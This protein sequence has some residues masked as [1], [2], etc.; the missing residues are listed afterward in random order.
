MKFY[1]TAIRGRIARVVFA[2]LL[3]VINTKIL[4]QTGNII[5]PGGHAKMVS[6]ILI[7]KQGKYLYSQEGN[8]AI[9]WDVKTHSQLYT[10]KND[11]KKM[12]LSNDGTKLLLGDSCYSTITGK[13]LFKVKETNPI[14][15]TDD[16]KIYTV[17]SGLFVTDVATQQQT[18]LVEFLYTNPEIVAM[19]DNDHVLVADN[20]G[21][22]VID[23]AQK[24]I[25]FEYKLPYGTTIFYL[26]T[27]HCI[28]D[29]T[30][31]SPVT[32][33]D[34][35]TGKVLK[36]IPKQTAKISLFSSGD[37]KYF[38]W[39][40]NDYLN[41]Y[42]VYNGATW[43][44]VRNFKTKEK[45]NGACFYEDASTAY[46]S[47]RSDINL[48]NTK[49]SGV[50]YTF[51]RQV[52]DL[53]KDIFNSFEYNYPSGILN[54]ITDDSVYKSID[55][56]R[57]KPFRHQSLPEA[58]T[59]AFS[60]TGDTVALFDDQK[61]GFIKNV[62]TGK[63]LIP[64][65]RLTDGA[66]TTE[67]DNFFFDK[68][69]SYAYYTVHNIPKQMHVLKRVN[70]KTGQSET[71]VT[72]HGTRG[73]TLHPDKD[74]LAALDEGYQYSHAKVWDVTTG[75]L[76]FDKDLGEDKYNYI[77]VS[78]DKKKVLL[79]TNGKP[80][81][82]DLA[83][84]TLIAQSK[85]SVGGSVFGSPPDLSIIVSGFNNG[86]IT[87]VNA[88]GDAL[89]DIKAHD[90]AVRRILFS[91]DGRLL[92]T[93]SEDQTIKVWLPQSGKLLG[94]LYLFNDG[95]D[96][97]F[98]DPYGR[99]DGSEGGMKRMYYYRNRIKVN[100]DVV[101]EKFYTPNLYQRLVNG[102]QFPPIDMIIN[103]PPHVRISYAQVTRNLDV[104]DDKT[105]TYSNTSGI[106]EITVN[107][108]AE[109][110]KVD[111]IRLFHNGKIV[112]LA[113]RGLF[114]T[115][116]TTG[117]DTKKYTLNLLPGVNNIRAVAL[118]G[119]RTES[120]PDEITIAYNSSGQANV[121]APVNK[122]GSLVDAVDHNATMHLVVVGI[123]AYK[124]PKMS[125]NYALADA[126]S[127][128]EEAERNA[129]TIITSVKTY[130]VTDDKAD[131]NGI[132]TA[133][134]EVQKN[135]KPQDVFVFYYAGH[136]VI[137]ERNKEFYLV[138]NDVADLK[139]VDEALEQHGIPSKMLQQYAINIAAQ[140]QVFILDACQS[141]G[142]FASLLAN[143]ANQ[144]KS[145]AV[146]ARST[147]TH[148]IAASGSQQFANE[149][150]QLGHGAF[151]YVL[152]KAMKG[153]AASDKMVT[154]NGLKHFLQVQVPELMKKYNGTAQ[155]PASYGLGNDFPV[156]VI[157]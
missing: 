19:L 115:D 72:F 108:S 67:R 69:G 17:G 16:S 51:K 3:I 118:N 15:S 10:F 116:N 41:T 111:E 103:P 120:E 2:F 78:G 43:A 102:E 23:I 66:A 142:A 147:G 122:G 68:S 136:G 95:N 105:P 54:L 18:R 79:I 93:V 152:L 76:L 94:T 33:R 27:L 153:E 62:V 48:L 20:G 125:L 107:A 53:G 90:A 124:N 139:N 87:A 106:A 104:V 25:G 42:T 112:N 52:A 110:D 137:S 40:G 143:D 141:A 135:A 55:M 82:Y 30:S 74:L 117:T 144:Q 157:K 119:Q 63:L 77:I 96:Y 101:Y 156:G 39:N 133:L 86:S 80:K 73:S 150:S 61:R 134:T 70:V 123:N 64:V 57:L 132:V 36:T 98:L 32:F 46:V 47:S 7:D 155:Y 151:T 127:F 83:T 109:D 138:P 22:R 35:Y 56:V 126:T 12:S 92:Y 13:S 154:I 4:A 121:P 148:W 88:A 91:P 100:L 65:M 34:I 45:I 89:Y 21:W 11:S 28:A 58:S 49:T 75:R 26:P 97:V 29:Y 59:I 8:K 129:K 99:F 140:K 85:G 84:G 38:I 37:S 81:V 6:N 44:P 128:K 1:H 31:E 114:V 146:V 113:T 130:F 145:L 14:F 24:K 9:M 60:P 71:M 131:K 149:F 50:S 5:V